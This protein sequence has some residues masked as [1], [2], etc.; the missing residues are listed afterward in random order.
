M[1]RR[2]TIVG[3]G[4]LLLSTAGCISANVR[5]NS[6]ATDRAAVVI[7]GEVYVVDTADGYIMKLDMKKTKPFKRAKRSD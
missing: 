4:V 3:L 7:D 5:D 1:Q 6:F 2:W